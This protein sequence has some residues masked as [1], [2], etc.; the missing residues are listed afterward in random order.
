MACLRDAE[1]GDNQNNNLK[2]QRS[3]DMSLTIGFFFL[4]ERSYAWLNDQ[5]SRLLQMDGCNLDDGPAKCDYSS[6]NTGAASIN[7][8]DRLLNTPI[9]P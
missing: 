1:P 5:S 9:M 2:Q 7:R 3:E 6:K 4:N 8:L